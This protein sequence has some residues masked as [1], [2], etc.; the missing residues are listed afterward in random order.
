VLLVDFALTTAAMVSFTVSRYLFR[1]PIEARFGEHIIRFRKRIRAGT[2]FSM[3]MLRL[4]HT[5]FSFVNYGAG[6]TNI[7]SART[8]WWTTQLGLLPGTMVFVFAGTRI[9]SL[10]IIAERGVAAIFDPLLFLVLILT[11]FLPILGR[12]CVNAIQRCSA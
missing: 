4:L 1:A 11:A 7:V 12:I 10:A 8:F 9:P 2:A 3:L 6:A 5:P